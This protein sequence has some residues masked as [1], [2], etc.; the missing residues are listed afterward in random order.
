MA[1]KTICVS[2]QTKPRYIGN[3]LRLLLWIKR[4]TSNIKVAKVVAVSLSKSIIL[5]FKELGRLIKDL[6]MLSLQ[7][8]IVAAIQHTKI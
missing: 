3:S 1:S 6:Q 8:L 7:F 5:I 4:A 2:K